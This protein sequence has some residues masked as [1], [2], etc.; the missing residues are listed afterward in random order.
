MPLIYKK[1]DKG[2][3]EIETRAQRLAPRLRSLLILV[4]GRRDVAA[5]RALVQQPTEDALQALQ[6][7][8]FV[9]VVGDS[10]PGPKAATQASPH[11][12]QTAPAPVTSP[13]PAASGVIPMRADS[14]NVLRSQAVRA[15]LDAVG[16]AGDGLAMRLEK[17]RSTP[18]LQPLLVQAARLVAEL[19][20]RAAGERFIAR[21]LTGG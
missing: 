3:A 15:L 16:P 7:Q 21:F 17:A 6:L 1:T 19:G 20:G 12:A 4:D 2:L 11:A 5:I 14:F 13:A 9:E 10:T 8:G 18:E